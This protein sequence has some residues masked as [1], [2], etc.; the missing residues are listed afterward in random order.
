MA[1]N[2]GSPVT[3]LVHVE[4]DA[5]AR[6][7]LWLVQALER[8]PGTQVFVRISDGHDPDSASALPTLLTLERMILRRGRA[9]GSDRIQRDE[10]A[11][12]RSEPAGLEPDIVIDLTAGRQEFSA[13]GAV[14]LRPLY[15]GQP[16]ETALGSAL[17][18]QG[19]PEIA[20]ERK[21]PGEDR[22]H[23]RLGHGLA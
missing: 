9:C 16:G 3:V 5:L 15:N 17:F 19:T 12:R 18:F 7:V 14:R 6:W 2:E 20:I 21:A 13:S 23:R 22:T 8:R 11:G 1:A 4:A 10:L